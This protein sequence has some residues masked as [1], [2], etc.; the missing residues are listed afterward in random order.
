LSGLALF[1]GGSVGVAAVFFAWWLVVDSLGLSEQ[2]VIGLGVAVPVAG[3]S[4]LVL[5]ALRAKRRWL[6]GA[7]LLGG[8]YA[9]ASCFVLTGLSVMANFN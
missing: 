8:G 3:C 1:A 6:V 4:A 5:W 9:A 7:T 2:A